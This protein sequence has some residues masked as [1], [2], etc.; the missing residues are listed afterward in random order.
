MLYSVSGLLNTSFGCTLS[1]VKILGNES[2]R[3]DGDSFGLLDWHVDG[4]LLILG[5]GHGDVRLVVIS[6]SINRSFG[7]GSGISIDICISVN[8]GISNSICLNFGGD[9]G[10]DG[11]VE[12]FLGVV[13]RDS[14]NGSSSN[15]SS[16][17]SEFH[18]KTL[19]F[20]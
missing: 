13:Q 3:F 9:V 17:E 12:V 8:I 5:S 11:G 2:I 18:F 6:F 16:K 10:Q 20:L 14:V 4:H 7:L 19:L 1:E 15:K